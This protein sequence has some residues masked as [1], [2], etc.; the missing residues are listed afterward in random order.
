MGSFFY[1]WHLILQSLKYEQQ[2]K[3]INIVFCFI[4]FEIYTYDGNGIM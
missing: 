4:F 1:V 3:T 2:E